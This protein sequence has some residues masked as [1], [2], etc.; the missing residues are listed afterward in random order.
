MVWLVHLAVDTLVVMA[1]FLEV[2]EVIALH[3]E[4]VASGDSGW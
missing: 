1:V 4:G 2:S 3:A